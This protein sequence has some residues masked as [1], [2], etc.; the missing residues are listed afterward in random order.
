MHRYWITFKFEPGSAAPLGARIGVG[1][2]AWS[3]E[4]ALTLT[5]DGVFSGNEA[6][7]VREV[8]HDVDVSTLDPGHVLPNMGN[9]LLRGVWFPVG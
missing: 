9:P 4:D 2:T 5:R 7:A 6:P 1:V 8:V 3:L